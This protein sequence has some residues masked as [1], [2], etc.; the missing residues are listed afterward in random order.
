VSNS[1]V[2]DISDLVQEYSGRIYGLALRL[3]QNRQDA[4]DVL[5]E[6]FLKVMQRLD[7]FEGRSAIYTWIHRIATNIAL[8]KLRRLRSIPDVDIAPQDFEE[9]AAGLSAASS[10]YFHDL[11]DTEFFRETMD[12]AIA[13]VPE[14]LRVVFILRDVE[15]LSTKET[16]DLLEITPANVKVRLMR[17]RIQ[18]RNRLAH[19]HPSKGARA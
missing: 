7:T 15:G 3:T 16:A 6:T 12:R 4:E 2:P 5:Q 17:A 19:L 13:R 18:L 10:N 9:L 8:G 1:A 14:P 11:E